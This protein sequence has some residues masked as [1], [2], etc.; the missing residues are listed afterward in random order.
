[1]RVTGPSAPTIQQSDCPTV[2]TVLGPRNTPLR[3]RARWRIYIYPLWCS[4]CVFWGSFWCTLGPF[5]AHWRTL[6]DVA[7]VSF[8]C[9]LFGFQVTSPFGAIFE[10][11]GA[12]FGAFGALLGPICPSFGPERHLLV[13]FGAHPVL[14]LLF[15]PDFWPKS[16]GSKKLR[17]TF[18]VLSCCGLHSLRPSVQSTCRRVCPPHFVAGSAAWPFFE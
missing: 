15:L 4:F 8:L 7:C 5:L 13:P 17:G 11:F 14:M 12:L 18:L 10:P 9:A 6:L 1:M 16:G 3:A 2:T